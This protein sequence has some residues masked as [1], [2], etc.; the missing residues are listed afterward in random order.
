MADDEFSS[1]SIE[2]RLAN[3]S[4][5]ARLSAYS[6]L[7][8][9]FARTTDETDPAF[10][11][12]FG[13]PAGVKDWVRDSNAV[14]QE[15]GVE[16]ACSLVQWGGKQAAKSRPEVVPSVVEKCLGSARAGTKTKAVELCLLYAEVEGDQGEGVISDLLPGLDLKQPKSVAGTVLVLSEL[17]RSFG[18]RTLKP[19]SILQSLPKIFAH[20]DATVRAQGTNLA[21]AL[22][23]YLG[24]AL[25]PSL[26]DLKPVQVK[27]LGEAFKAADEKGEG[28]G[29]SGGKQ[30]RWTRV[31][32]R[33][34]M[35]KEAEGQLEGIKPE[36]EGDGG[37]AAD[38]DDSPAHDLAMDPYD[39]ATPFD[40]LSALPPDFYTNLSSTKWKDRSDLALTPLLALLDTPRLAPGSY[41]EL[42]RALAGRMTDANVMCVTLA[43]G[44]LEK[45][46]TGLRGAFKVFREPTV[47][48]LLAR[49]KEKKPSVLDA[50]AKALDAVF[51]S[52]SGISD[53][54]DE[55]STFALDKNPSVRQQTLLFLA[56][57][58]RS[59]TSLP[60]KSDL[61]T[62][63]PLLL[64]SLED[65]GEPVRAAAAEALGTLVK[66]VGERALG[67]IVDG[68]D[69]GRKAKVR[70]QAESAVVKKPMAAAANPALDSP[71]PPPPKASA[72]PARLM[73]KK[74]PAASTSAP[75]AAAK[76]PPPAAPSGKAPPPSKSAPSEPLKYKFSQEDAE[77]RAEELLP[78]AIVAELGDANWKVRL[79][80]IEA[81]H[82]WLGTDES[83]TVE[84][85]VI[86]RFLSKKPGWKES[87]FQVS[88]KMFAAFQ[89]LAESSPSF[90]KAAAAITIPALSE[91]LGDMKLKTP[92]GDA[93]LVFAEKSSLQFVLSQAYEPMA[94]QK[95]PKA[96][97]DSLV[98]VDR[99]IRDFGIGGLSV[100]ELIEFLKVGLKSTNAAVRTNATKALVTL[101]L[102]VGAD[103]TTFLQDLNPALLTTIESEFDKVASKSPPDPTR[104]AADAAV[105][106]TTGGGK[107]KGKEDDGLDDLFPRVDLDKLV[108][109]ATTAGCNDANW[110]IR[111]ESL[112]VI[113]STLEANKRLKPSTLPDLTTALKLRMADSNKIVQSLA[114]DVVARIATGMG[115]AFDKLARIFAGPVAGV[116]ADQKANIRAAGLA[117]LT[118]MADASGLEPMMGGFDK[119]LEAQNPLLRKELLGWLEGRF[120]NPASYAHLDL[121]GLAG[122]IIACLEDRNADV[123]KSA[124]AL[125]PVVVA[126]A[127]YNYVLDQTSK[128]KPA[129]RS[130]VLPLIE[131]ARGS[132][133]APAAAA[134]SSSAPAKGPAPPKPAGPARATAKVLRPGVAPPPPLP[135]TPPPDA[136]PSRTP[137][138]RPRQSL[139]RAKAPTPVS[140]SSPA[141]AAREAPF[142][143][144]DPDAKKYRAAKETGSLKWVVDGTPR[145]D[146]VEALFQ[147]MSANT[148]PDLLAQLFS[149]DHNSERDFVAA[150]STL[151]EA[152]RDPGGATSA[153][154]DLAPDELRRRLVAN[155]DVMFKYITL[156][157]G[158]T[159]TTITVK[160]LDLVEHLIEVLDTESHKLSDYEAH[161]LLLQLI[162]KVGD[163]KETIRLRVRALFKSLCDV[164]P[165]SKVFATILEHGLVS[166]NARTR[167]ESADELGSLFQRH[168]TSSFPIVKALP[169]IAK[170]ISDRDASVRTAALTAIGSA[171][172]ILGADQVY[173]LVG[174]MPDKEHSMLE[175]RLK[176]TAGPAAE[177]AAATPRKAIP[178]G[179]PQRGG[180]PRVSTGG[181]SLPGPRPSLLPPRQRERESSTPDPALANIDIDSLVDMIRT[182]DVAK[183]A[184]V[185]K[186]LQVEITTNSNRLVEHADDIIDNITSQ[187]AVAFTGL[188]GS[189]GQSVLR[190]CK[191]LMQ[192][193][194]AFFDHKNLGQAVA[195]AALTS[196]LAELTGRLL[197]TAE[198]PE[199]EAISSLSKVL[200]MVLIRIF[201]HSDQTACF[202]ALFSVL[203]QATNDLRELR[204]NDLTERA[205]YAE[206]VMKCLWKVSK[207]VKE[208]LEAGSLQAPRLL[209]DINIFL[210]RIPP[211][212]WRRRATDN[213][214]L[215]DMPLRTVKTILQQIVSVYGEQVFDYLDEVDSAENS[216]VY[217]Y[218]F[219]L[220]SNTGTTGTAPESSRLSRQ[221]SS[222][223][224]FG[225]GLR[226]VYAKELPNSPPLTSVGSPLVA[227][228]DAVATN[229][230]SSTLSNGSAS[231]TSASSG[232]GEIEMN[233]RLKIIFDLIGDPVQSRTGIA[234]LYEFQKQH[235]EAENRIATWMSGTGNYFQTYLKRALDNLAQAD[236]EKGPPPAPRTLFI[237]LR[238]RLL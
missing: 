50:L 98:W 95:A 61:A 180:I 32:Q 94:K 133:P 89:L 150:L 234:E 125:L 97:A 24:P 196:L 48:P 238:L 18:P 111:K 52:L 126:R 129:S 189:S 223:S 218:L 135:P 117:T 233:Q 35:V 106:A 193:L 45:I 33:E 187:M 68:L 60:T 4:W 53:I 209:R 66:C 90:T 37:A 93:L 77:S 172:T 186:Q 190:L 100:R 20:A 91:K 43:A 101:K 85:E 81:L 198:N 217:Q 76:K 73:A 105:A 182:D 173:K 188:D 163:G 15:K 47:A 179:L 27:E 236:R 17:I 12:F 166:K 44:C 136:P 14:S 26:K 69:D 216:F 102:Y 2:D 38:D 132:A 123:R 192:T 202:T 165:F 214:P 22:H 220:A 142:R 82:S 208:S 118:A 197:D 46:A 59:T 232:G 171:Y 42:V 170:L 177:P 70:E 74:P 237:D 54:A 138:A 96:L 36:V 131:A 155:V 178:S 1:L 30:T 41:D 158:L 23:G 116:L 104:V 204:G 83:A 75:P 212:E 168:G 25:D 16:A 219:R 162:N 191:H 148:Q 79:A 175:E 169:I 184:E 143:S 63:S 221:P 156:R 107:G 28:F 183:C 72:P 115:K 210:I 225:T 21:L 141:P 226:T 159:S 56:R 121:T 128:L 215:A 134:A 231:P 80:A 64:K 87:N 151:D 224:S 145:P 122:P 65:S 31:Q 213:V 9:T 6:E 228:G 86:V 137:A 207:T 92:A 62:L 3:K 13:Y 34:R 235:P 152:A 181:S 130:T 113:Q 49:T 227:N 161:A 114:L 144:S 153:A 146:Q 10:G 110:K 195:T 176:R 201:H 149:K 185:L 78:A 29:G 109:S 51:S 119:P 222:S 55:L 157:I 39:F 167:T 112:E 205:K 127:G 58:L 160:C 11:P 67:G 203:Q 124:T 120:D 229:G 147:Q 84:A 40:V 71:G 194:S 88:G 99:A 103:I 5:K 174:K 164:Y 139:A 140:R 211:A 154:Y 57:S 199:T 108:S 230:H 206:L 19:Q 200:N 8:D 7:I